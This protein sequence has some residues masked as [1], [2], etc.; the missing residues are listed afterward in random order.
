MLLFLIP[1]FWIFAG[2]V[3]NNIMILLKSL[4]IYIRVCAC[5]CIHI[6]IYIHTHTHEH[7]YIYIYILVYMYSASEHEYKTLWCKL[8]GY[9]RFRIDRNLPYLFCVHTTKLVSWQELVFEAFVLRM[10]PKKTQNSLLVSVTN[11]LS[12]SLTIWSYWLY[13]LI[14]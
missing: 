8:F 9:I 5:V 4:L 10:G 7:I 14:G 11:I 2:M 1:T 3:V 13:F 6:Y 12:D